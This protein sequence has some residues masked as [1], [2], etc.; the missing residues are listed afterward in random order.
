[1][2]WLSMNSPFGLL[3]LFEEDNVLVGLKWGQEQEAG[4]TSLL[5]EAK[6]QL[7]AYFDGRLKVFDL[8]LAPSGTDFQRR[9]WNVLEKIPHAATRTYGDIAK[10][11]GTAPRAIGL[12]CGRNPI[13]LIIPCH[14]VVAAAGPGLGGYSGGTGLDTKLAL[15]KLE[16]ASL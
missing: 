15:L 6:S 4:S 14:R 13:P 11:V 8:P 7:E 9:V 10:S 3:T 2:A 16:G 5:D 12:A 1:M